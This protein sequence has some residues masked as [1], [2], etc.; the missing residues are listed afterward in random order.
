MRLEFL[1][2]LIM[3]QLS[4][5]LPIWLPLNSG[6]GEEP[7]LP[8]ILSAGITA[9]AGPPETGCYLKI[10]TRQIQRLIVN[11][12]TNAVKYTPAG[13][14]VKWATTLVREEA[15]KVICRYIISDNG[16]GIPADF[17]QIMYE[18][19]TQAKAQHS[20]NGSGL[21]LAIVK[22]LVDLLSGTIQCHSRLGEGTAFTVTLPHFKADA[23]EVAAFLQEGQQEDADL[24]KG[25]HVLVCED[26][27]INAQIIRRLLLL[28]KITSDW[29]ENGAEA[30]RMVRENTTKPYQAVLMDI[31]M[32]VM[33][34][35]EATR[36]IRN[37]NKQ[38]PIIAL[39]ANNFA[40]DV[41]KSLASGMNNHLAKPIDMK[42][43]LAV[44]Q[45]VF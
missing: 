22:K 7:A 44:L 35:Y 25:R 18:P 1:C 26:N 42:K 28:K 34:G 12:L 32:P 17:Q 27:Q 4:S 33:D 5:A 38:V 37:F 36:Q 3:K 29:A 20:S 30:V 19:F 40:E 24:Y 9:G 2:S 45:K 10:D 11:L 31:R 8:L 23:K 43:L 41:D 6:W 39:S 16:P 14:E 15:D 13:G 21:G